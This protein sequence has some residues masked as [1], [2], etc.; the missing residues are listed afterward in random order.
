M[1]SERHFRELFDRYLAGTC[2][3]QEKAVIEKW[4][5]QGGDTVEADPGLSAAEKARMLANIHRVQDQQ[6]R[7]AILASKREKQ[8]G[9]LL[10][11]KK[12]RVAAVWAGFLLATAVSTWII[13]RHSPDTTTTAAVVFN[14]VTT[15]KGEIRQVI[16]PDSSIV[17]LN[18]NSVLSY[19]PDF[20]V[21]RQVKLSGEALF[22]VTRNT[23]H[24]FTVWTS[25]SLATTVL[26]TQFNINSYDQGEEIAITVVSGKVSVSKPGSTIGTL[27]SAQAIRYHKA[28][29]DHKL[30]T[31]IHTANL[32]DWT[33]G[34]WKYD[35]M[36]S[37]DLVLLLQNQYNITLT[38]QRKG[39]PL[40][41]GLSVNFTRQ[42][43]PGEIIETFCSFAGCRYRR[44]SAASFEIY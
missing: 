31:D 24:P 15:S 17:Q 18:A 12:W 36:R 25:D 40:Q 20:A 13:L 5:E 16:L 34:E 7:P 2:T 1:E 6:M 3:A 9:L 42:Q 38:I 19:H 30:L 39:K 22:T 27:T 28:G 23:Q 43:T 32:T 37:G 4:F 14:Q 10:F 8:P 35:N 44:L 21:Q 41:T 11:L 33:K 29:G 26:G